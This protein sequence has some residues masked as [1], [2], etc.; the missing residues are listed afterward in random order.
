MRQCLSCSQGLPPETWVCP[1]CGYQPRVENEILC[2]A[3]ESPQDS[4]GFPTAFFPQLAKIET[5]H[6]WYKARN[7]LIQWAL[8]AYFP[9]ARCFFEV[10]CGNGYVLSGLQ[11]RF[12]HLLLAGS[13]MFCEGLHFASQ[14]LRKVELWQMDARHLPFQEEFDVVGAFDVIEHIEEDERVL[15]ELYKSVKRDRG[16]IIITVPQHPALWSKTDT[17]EH[18]VRRYTAKDLEAK[19]KRVGFKL[20][21]ITSFMFFLLPLMFLSR[22]LQKRHNTDI[23]HSREYNPPPLLNFFFEMIMNLEILFIRSGISFPCGGSLL[24]VGRT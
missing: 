15:A 6:F 19:M 20:E 9:Q 8:N 12:P 2:F 7:R 3:E 14:R 24:V 4:S 13:D 16:G 18:H 10:G 11:S 17:S 22:L 1:T 5:T 21:R 23:A